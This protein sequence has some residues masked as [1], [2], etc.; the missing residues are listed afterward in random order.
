MV[1]LWWILGLS[2]IPECPENFTKG[3]YVFQFHADASVYKLQYIAVSINRVF[4]SWWPLF[5]WALCTKKKKCLAKVE[6][7]F[8]AIKPVILS[9]WLFRITS[10]SYLFLSINV[11]HKSIYPQS[12]RYIHTHLPQNWVFHFFQTCSFQV[13]NNYPRS[14]PLLESHH[15]SIP[16]TTF[17][18]IQL[19]Y[20]SIFSSVT[21]KTFLHNCL[22]EPSESEN[23]SDL[24]YQ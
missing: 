5:S 22:S 8:I 13:L 1:L 9:T 4:L 3:E 2:I 16:S 15:I 17:A 19:G 20:L 24:M 23:I 7:W 11:R 6:V 18:Y 12:H 10:D 14:F 21:R